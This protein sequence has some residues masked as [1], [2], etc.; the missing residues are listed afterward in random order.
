MPAPFRFHELEQVVVH[1]VYSADAGPGNTDIAF[2]E[3]EEDFAH[4]LGTQR[5]GVVY[6]GDL[7][8]TIF[9]VQ[10]FDFVGDALSARLPKF[11]P[12]Y[13]LVAEGALIRAAST[14]N[15]VCH[16]HFDV[17]VRRRSGGVYL[18]MSGIRPHAGNG[19]VS[20]SSMK[21]RRE[22]SMR[23]TFFGNT[24]PS[25][26]AMTPPDSNVSNKSRKVTSPSLRTP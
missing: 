20:R 13:V 26:S 21:S 8:D 1:G 2:V 10:Q 6:E 11:A 24:S 14:C 23:R 17:V 25:K 4:A 9:P 7:P 18:E 12:E 16:R 19:S 3:Q 22:F 5:E 15:Q